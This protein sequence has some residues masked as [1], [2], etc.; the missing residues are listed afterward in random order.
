MSLGR[1]HICLA[2]KDYS[3]PIQLTDFV[4]SNLRIPPLGLSRRAE[5]DRYHHNIAAEV[6]QVAERQGV[7]CK[8]Q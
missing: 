4:L 1:F 6:V 2:T 3:Q 8:E 7:D 5:S